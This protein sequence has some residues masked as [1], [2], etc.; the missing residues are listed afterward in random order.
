MLDKKEVSPKELYQAHLDRIHERN[1]K[2]NAYLSVFEDTPSTDILLPTTLNGIPGIIKDNILIEGRRSTGGSKI[3][4]NY[5]AT[6]RGIVSY[7]GI[8]VRYC[9]TEAYLRAG[10]SSRTYANGG[11]PQYYRHHHQKC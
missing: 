5:T 9:R 3:L 7:A 6:Y 8:V 4:E 2:I 10:I 1:P 11:K